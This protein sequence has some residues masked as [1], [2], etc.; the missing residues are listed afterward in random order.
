[1]QRCGR[2]G[3]R[4]VIVKAATGFSSE[5]AGF[6]QSL[7]SKGGLVARV[8][9]EGLE[10]RFGD[11][12]IDVVADEVHERERPQAEPGYGG[13][14][15]VNGSDVGDAF[16]E[17]AQRFPVERPRHPVDDEAGRVFHRDGHFAPL[18]H[19]GAGALHDFGGGLQGGRYFHQFHQRSGIEKV[20]SDDPAGMHASAGQCRDGE[21]G[22]VGSEDAIGSGN[23]LQLAKNG[24]FHLYIFHYG[25]Q[26]E[27]G[28]MEGVQALQWPDALQ[29]F[30]RFAGAEFAF[31]LHAL[32]R[33]FQAA[34][35]PFQCVRIGVVKQHFATCHG[36]HLCY[37]CAHS[38][39]SDDS[40]GHFFLLC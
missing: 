33:F 40:C 27:F 17:D 11:R 1:L 28:I 30:R 24:A 36:R 19:E 2:H 22:R 20:Q 29:Y 16:I 32:Q 13:H 5:V 12:V 7:L 18:L 26:H 31:F 25:L 6:R 21:R 9:K 3:I 8:V 10:Y 34:H 23:F 4:C 39:G 35:G 14:G 37:A 15:V 38:A